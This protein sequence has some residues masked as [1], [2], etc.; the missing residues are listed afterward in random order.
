MINYAKLE[1]FLDTKKKIHLESIP[2]FDE[3][4]KIIRNHGEDCDCHIC[5]MMYELAH[6]RD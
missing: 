2:S 4:L 5:A 3:M 6:N 1:Q